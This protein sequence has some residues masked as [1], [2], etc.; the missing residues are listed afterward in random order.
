MAGI[1][2]VLEQTGHVVTGTDERTTGHGAE[3]IPKEADVVIYSEAITRGSAG[4]GELEAAR[5][6]G[7]PT[8]RRI[9]FIARIMDGATG[10]AVSGAHGKSTTTALVGWAL[11]QADKDPTVFIGADVTAFGGSARAGHGP[12][13]VS[14]SCEWN[15]QFLVLHPTEFII[16]SIDREHLDTYPGGLPDIIA[17]FRQAAMNVVPNGHVL[18]NADDIHIREALHDVDRSI[19][20]V[21]YSDDAMYRLSTV[22]MDS[23]TLRFSLEFPGGQTD[24]YE[25]SLVGV[26]HAMNAALAIATLH[27]LRVDPDRVKQAIASF[28]GLKRRFERFIDTPEMA[29]IDDY[30][31]HPAEI[32]ATIAAAKA[33]Y[34]DRRLIAVFQPHLSQ[35]TTDLFP[36]FV[37][38]LQAAN[39]VVLLDTYEP[40]GRAHVPN[41]RTSADIAAEL[42]NRNVI[43][44]HVASNESAI[45]LIQQEYEPGDVVLTMG[46]T[47][48]WKVAEAVA[49]S[50]KKKF[51]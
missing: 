37:D 8:L 44:H 15:K 14:E 50:Y 38:A 43:V 41:A 3:K 11:V 34:N 39:Q 40:A 49:K 51:A 5:A 16:T 1:H 36:E 13:V 21:G 9:E 20:Y 25:S 18:A 42:A 29:V 30:A 35:R 17:A 7:I 28:P 33:R 2:H 27:E 10:V 47:T 22:S 19:V 46:A 31:H 26:H 32:A 12:Y 48:V 45:E 6:R 23:G 4:F 24:V